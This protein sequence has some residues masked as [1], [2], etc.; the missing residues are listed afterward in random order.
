MLLEAG[1]DAALI[2][3]TDKGIME[4]LRASEALLGIDAYCMQYIKYMR[5]K[6]KEV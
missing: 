6:A 4:I 2:D 3:P 5:K 1:L